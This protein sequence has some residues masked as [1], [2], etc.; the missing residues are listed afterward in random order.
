MLKKFLTLEASGGIVLFFAAVIAMLLANSALGGWYHAFVFYPLGLQFG[1]YGF[2]APLELWIND[3]LMAVFF[4][5]VGMEIKRELLEGE[6]SSFKQA[7]L[8]FVA[9][10]GGVALPALIYSWFNWDSPENLRGWAIPTAT[11]IAFSLGVLALFGTRVPLGL[12]VFLTAVAVI[13]DLI[14][15]IVIAVFYSAGLELAYLAG[16]AACIALLAA[17]R[18]KRINRFWPYLLIGTVMWFFTLKSGIHATIAG[19]VLG[20]MMPLALPAKNGRSMLKTCEEALHPWVVYGIMPLFAF[21]NAG[22]SMHGVTPSSLREPVTAGILAGLF[23]GKQLGIF[24]TSFLLIKLHLARK[25]EGASWGQF[26][27]VCMI[28]GIGFTMSLFIGGLAFTDIQHATA[29]RLGVMLGSLL[30]AVAGG[31]LLWLTLQKR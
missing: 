30:S 8:P 26:Y 11:D 14:A 9:A 1:E 29:I 15:I 27:A 21:A 23:A 13:D 5:L 6:L 20:A 12:K 22:I 4:L 16:S 19:V 18:W 28:A 10:A 25:P 2:S 7:I 24:L 3:G 31:T 17:L